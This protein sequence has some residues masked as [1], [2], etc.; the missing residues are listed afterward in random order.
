MR[1]NATSAPRTFAPPACAPW[2]RAASLAAIIIICYFL[3]DWRIVTFFTFLSDI[4]DLTIDYFHA[5]Y[6]ELSDEF[7]LLG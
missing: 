2:G 3:L 4:V 7:G 1:P 6:V 5:L